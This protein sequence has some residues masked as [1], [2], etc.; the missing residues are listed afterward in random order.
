MFL[1]LTCTINSWEVGRGGDNRGLW[2]S[3]KSDYSIKQ[4]VFGW[5]GSGQVEGT[6]KTGRHKAHSLR[7]QTTTKAI[8]CSKYQGAQKI[9]LLLVEWPWV[10]TSYAR[11]CANKN[12]GFP[13]Q[14]T[15]K[16]IFS[17]LPW[18][19]SPPVVVFFIYCLMLYTLGHTDIFRLNG[20][21]DMCPGFCGEWRV[22]ALTVE[23]QGSGLTTCPGEADCTVCEQ[24]SQTPV[25]ALLSH[26]IS[27]TKQGQR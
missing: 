26:Q 25:H 2:F 13:V 18:S 20:D 7:V 10:G 22:S 23:E 11:P 12:V 24:G 15:E 8:V 16:K 9:Y 6:V 17:L 3:V 27:L 19:F 1:L 21:P 4:V 5:T 14:K